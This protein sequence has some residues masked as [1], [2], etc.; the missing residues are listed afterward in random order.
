MCFKYTLSILTIGSIIK[1]SH[2]V[3]YLQQS[4]K[5]SHTRNN[6]NEPS[7]FFKCVRAVCDCYSTRVVAQKTRVATTNQTKLSLFLETI[8]WRPLILVIYRNSFRSE[9]DLRIAPRELIK[10]DVHFGR[11]LLIYRHAKEKRMCRAA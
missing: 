6:I 2:P 11:S 10:C 8:I 5:T 9:S 4:L 1:R 7:A 3:I